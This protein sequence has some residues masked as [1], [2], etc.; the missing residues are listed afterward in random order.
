MFC[1]YFLHLFVFTQSRNT[2][3]YLKL[4]RLFTFYSI[5]FLLSLCIQNLIYERRTQTIYISLF[6]SASF[7]LC[8]SY[9]SFTS[10]ILSSCTWYIQVS[11]YTLSLIVI[12]VFLTCL[13]L[14]SF[15]Q[16]Q[17]NILWNFFYFAKLNL[18]KVSTHSF[19]VRMVR[20]HL[21]FLDK[22]KSI[23]EFIF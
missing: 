14:F 6:P 9:F 17:S 8:F 23:S 22:K 4:F 3:S 2:K 5:L 12:F 20:N 1:H 11:F 16:S 15:F 19:N 10:V 18:R 13:F 21:P 7:S